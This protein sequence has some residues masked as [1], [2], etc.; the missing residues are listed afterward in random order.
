MT[1]PA[2]IINELDAERLDSLLEQPAFA[3][4]SIA[5]ALNEE[6][7]RAEIVPPAEIPSDVVTMNSRVRF[8]DLT[9]N[10]ERVRT[11]VYPASLQDSSDQLSV[12]APLGAALLG[13]RIG[14]EIS[15]ELPNGE[16]TRVKV[17]ELL[18]QPE[19]AGELHR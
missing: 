11:L 6:L 9:S 14:D 4:T 5:D 16:E 1:K 2:I 8:L 18:Y 7:D 10:E 19:A 13:L 17:L 15:W 3:D 12:M